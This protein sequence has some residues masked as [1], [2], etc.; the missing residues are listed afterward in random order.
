MSQGIVPEPERFGDLCEKGLVPIITTATHE[1]TTNQP[2]PDNLPVPL[3]NPANIKVC[4]P[5]T[6]NYID[7][8][9]QS[10]LVI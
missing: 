10:T 2:P 6:C 1:V 9:L 8:Y 7:T 4:L 3:I 5:L